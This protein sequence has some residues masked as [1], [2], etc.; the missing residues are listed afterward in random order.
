MI[1]PTP[2][3]SSSALHTGAN[4]EGPITW[5]QVIATFG[6][7]RV[8]GPLPNV[9]IE[10]PFHGAC[11]GAPNPKL[12][13]RYYNETVAAATNRMDYA[14]QRLPEGCNTHFGFKQGSRLCH[15]CLSNHK[16]LGRDRC[17]VCPQTEQNVVFLVFAVILL[18]GGGVVVVWMAIKDAGNADQSEI[19]RKI[20]FNFL[21]VSALAAGF[22]LHWPKELEALFDF[23]GAISTAGEHILSPDCSVQNISPAA[24]FYGKQIGFALIPPCLIVL[25]YIIW[26][27]IGIVTRVP[28]RERALP[29]THTP[30]DKM[31]VTICVLLYFFWPTLLN[32]TFRLFSCREIGNLERMYLMADFEE[33]CYVGRH[34]LLVFCVG[35]TQIVLYAVGLPFLVFLFL[36]RHRHELKKPVVKFRYAL[37]FAG[38]RQKTY[39]W[40]CVVALR[41]EST[42]M[43]AVFGPSR[44][45]VLPL[46]F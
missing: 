8:P 38:F 41:K 24:L 32:Q 3:F 10:C 21:Q 18:I 25:I 9:F 17:S 26:K 36:Y 12:Q 2:P 46:L 39:Y 20:M 45:C 43:L 14:A 30:K 1:S 19:I 6:Y 22:P 44:C 13:G 34:L 23:Q 42:I 4:C 27:L 11:L 29:T 37:F 7:W 15:T 35:I 40:E 33:P 5:N 16:R 31:V 28:W